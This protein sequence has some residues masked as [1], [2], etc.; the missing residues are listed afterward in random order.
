MADTHVSAFQADVEE[1][2]REVQAAK[3]R[4]ADAK[5]RLK[6]K[7][8]ETAPAEPAVEEAA[9]PAPVTRNRV[10]RS[11]KKSGPQTVKAAQADTTTTP[12]SK[13][14]AKGS[15]LREPFPST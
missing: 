1:A 15:G 4:L 10:R 9:P 11:T 6:A 14:K 5:D 7:Q 12:L 8:A 2:E 13:P 3:N